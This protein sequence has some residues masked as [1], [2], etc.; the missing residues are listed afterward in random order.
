GYFVPYEREVTELLEAENTLLVEVE[1]PDEERKVGKRL[2]TGVFSHWDG[3]DPETNPGGIWL[4]VELHQSGPVRLGHVRCHTEAVSDGFAQLRFWAPLDSALPAEATLRWTISPLNFA[5]ET[6]H[7]EQRRRLAQGQQELSGFLKLR[8]PRLWWTHDLGA[9]NLYTI[10]LD[11][12][13]NGQLSDH[14][15]FTFGIRRFELRNWIPHLNGVRF[16]AKGN[17]YPP[18]DVRIAVMTREDYDRDLLL[19]RECHMNLLRVH[20]HVEHPAFYEAANAQGVLLWQDMPLQWLYEPAVLPE[21]RR[22][23]REMVRLLYNHPSVAIWCMHNEAVFIEDTGDESP[24]ARWRTYAS[25]LG[26]N[27]N[28]SVLDTQLAQLAREEDPWRP[29]VRSSGELE[30]PGIREG[31]DSHAYF[32]WYA[33]YGPLVLAERV[34]R[35]FPNNGRF[36]TEFGAQS[37]PNVESCLR[38]MHPDIRKLDAE[39]LRKRYS[40]QPDILANWVDWRAAQ[41]LGELVQMT[42]DYQI[43]INRYYID[44][45]RVAKYQPT[46]GIVPFMF[47]DSNPAV[48]WSIIDYWRVPKRSYHAMAL[49]FSPQYV[50]AIFEPRR[51]R[52]GEPLPLAL[53]AMNDAQHAVAGAQFDAWLRDAAGNELAHTQRT[54]NLAADCL[55]FEV[56]RLR[57]TPRYAGRYTLTLALRGANCATVEHSYTI[58][59]EV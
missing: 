11:V 20:A 3:I 6:Q 9:P 17:N 45:L 19:A 42:Q 48:A 18:G 14:H 47:H 32:G 23:T 49:S 46:G 59:V 27:W 38:F 8:D 25:A 5:G 15:S 58:E 37:F 53:Y 7:V 54:L 39:L 55:A 29:V 52:V 41:S 28:R 12:L 26:Y 2:I 33:S 21:A 16:L 40:F 31:T 44:R 13:L 34:M 1:C 50:C 30:I 43:F 4:P 10:S 24:R 36:V 22:Q 51:Y 57:F 35:R 56:E